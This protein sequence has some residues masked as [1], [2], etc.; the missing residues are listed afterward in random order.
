MTA[1]RGAGPAVPP[2]GADPPPV[3]ASWRRGRPWSARCTICGEECR[4]RRSRYVA[5]HYDGPRLPHGN[6]A[7]DEPLFCLGSDRDVGMWNGTGLVPDPVVA[8]CAAEQF[9]R[10][11][12]AAHGAVRFVPD[13]GLPRGIALVVHPTTEVTR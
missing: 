7:D 6:P 12:R 1:A 4:L 8:L 2:S 3:V 9:S 5:H 11:T 13:P 10:L